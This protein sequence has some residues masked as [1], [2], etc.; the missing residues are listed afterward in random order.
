MMTV[1]EL[2]EILSQYPEDI[3]VMLGFTTVQ[4][5]YLD[6]DFYF[7]DSSNPAQAIGPALIIE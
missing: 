5:I 2:I 7:A 4:D 6:N 1:G 3:P